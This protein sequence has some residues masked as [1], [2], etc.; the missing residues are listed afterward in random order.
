MKKMS[1]IWRLGEISFA[2]LLIHLL[3]NSWIALLIA[4]ATAL[5]IL[6]A[7]EPS[8]PEQYSAS[9][10]LSVRSTANSDKWSNQLAVS[11]ANA[12]TLTKAINEQTVKTD[13]TAEELRT[14]A[15]ANV[16]A[17]QIKS[18]NLITVTAASQTGEEAYL[19]LTSLADNLDQLAQGAKLTNVSLGVVTAPTM[20]ESSP[21]YSSQVILAVIGALAMG[22]IS[23]AAILTVRMIDYSPATRK[24]ADR[25]LVLPVAGALNNGKGGKGI[26]NCL[27]LPFAENADG[28]YLQRLHEAAAYLLED[29][30]SDTK[31]LQIVPLGHRK[32]RNNKAQREAERI[33]LNLSLVMADAGKHICLIDATAKV[34]A[35]L[36]IAP[37][38]GKQIYRYSDYL[39]V[40]LSEKET[41]QMQGYDKVIS[42]RSEMSADDDGH[43]IWAF[44]AGSLSMQEI[45][46]RTAWSNRAVGTSSLFL[47]GM[48][49][50]ADASPCRRQIDGD[51]DSEIDLL[52]W[53]L[54]TLKVMKRIACKW[55]IALVLVTAAVLAVG[56][57]ALPSNYQTDT[58]FS[59]VTADAATDLSEETLG[60]T[61]EEALI[62]MEEN[63]ALIYNN[64]NALYP[65]AL[66]DD[67]SSL[68]TAMPSVWNSTAVTEAIKNHLGYTDWNEKLT[69]TAN[70]K[71]GSFTLSVVGK[72]R[73]KLEAIT[74]AFFEIVP[75]ISAQTAGGLTYFADES[76][77]K[78]S[79]GN[80]TALLLLAWTAVILA[81]GFYAL[82]KGYRDRTLLLSY[83]V[84]EA[85]GTEVIGKAV[86]TSKKIRRSCIENDVFD[87]QVAHFLYDWIEQHQQGG[88]L[89]CT[90]AL[91]NEGCAQFAQAACAYLEKLGKRVKVIEADETE[92][93]EVLRS[94]YD[95]LLLDISAA[96]PKCNVQS[97]AER[98]DGVLFVLRSGYADSVRIALA[99][100]RL[101]LHGKLL[102]SVI[103][104]L[105]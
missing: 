32:K 87:A 57:L 65:T 103:T 26:D 20:P 10:T 75:T 7:A 56:K 39:T 44:R 72:N 53:M 74:N 66:P 49:S 102:G 69:V 43:T 93:L 19:Y 84:A 45:N 63:A 38:E 31:Y 6:T 97:L 24:A 54:A 92:Q 41:I 28:S 3:K 52:K 9:I 35:D 73:E 79:G 91:K 99:I 21:N 30:K 16:T 80:T 42:A 36:G 64:G 40:C 95:Y 23:C 88:I 2:D 94:S 25:L 46:D 8:M 76:Q 77:T 81:G 83:E 27:P 85:T 104:Y 12:A 67:L 58:V 22:F 71:Q 47:Y 98:A 51:D 17:E 68:V 13:F 1:S 62:W 101:N 4:A 50:I 14:K 37:S 18:S 55:L 89:M 15:S 100:E 60:M 96:Q 82:V 34:L 5:M 78:T 105:S 11:T 61:S 29:E 90:S 33:A 59:I 48:H 70:E 86:I